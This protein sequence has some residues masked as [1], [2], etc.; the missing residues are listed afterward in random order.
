[1][2]S[3]NFCLLLSTLY[4]FRCCIYLLVIL[5]FEFR[6][7]STP[8]LESIAPSI[9]KTSTYWASFGSFRLNTCQKILVFYSYNFCVFICI[10]FF[11]LESSENDLGAVSSPLLNIVIIS[12]ETC[13]NVWRDSKCHLHFHLGFSPSFANFI[14]CFF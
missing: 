13:E 6:I 12:V 3:I 10:L 5:T 7:H 11:A 9:Q 14:S 8:I 1:M 4:S 2:G